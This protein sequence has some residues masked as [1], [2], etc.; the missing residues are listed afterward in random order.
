MNYSELANWDGSLKPPSV[1]HRLDLLSGPSTLGVPSKMPH[2][3]HSSAN[4]VPP[5]PQDSSST[6]P[7]ASDED[8]ATTAL[9]LPDSDGMA[10]D[11]FSSDTD[12][13][14][15]MDAI[16]PHALEIE[17]AKEREDYVS[18]RSVDIHLS[19]QYPDDDAVAIRSGKSVEAAGERERAQSVPDGDSCLDADGETDFGSIDVAAEQ[20]GFYVPVVFNNNTASSQHGASS[21]SQVTFVNAENIP[22]QSHSQPSAQKI[23]GG[24]SVFD[25]DVDKQLSRPE[26]FRG[27]LRTATPPRAN[28]QSHLR[29]SFNPFSS[30]LTITDS[31]PLSVRH[32]KRS[33]FNRAYIEVPSLPSGS[34]HEDYKPSTDFAD[35]QHSVS[36]PVSRRREYSPISSMASSCASQDIPLLRTR[37]T[38]SASVSGFRNQNMPPAA[39]SSTSRAPTVATKKRNRIS[40]TN[41]PRKKARTSA[42]PLFSADPTC[43]ELD[44]AFPLKEID[45]L[46]LPYPSPASMRAAFRH[47]QQEHIPA[48]VNTAYR[49]DSTPH[50]PPPPH[51]KMMHFAALRALVEYG[52]S[53]TPGITSNSIDANA[54]L[55]SPLP[56]PE[57]FDLAPHTRAQSTAPYIAFPPAELHS[58]FS[59][60]SEKL[61]PHPG[62]MYS[63]MRGDPLADPF[64]QFM[65]SDPGYDE[66][67]VV[68]P[69]MADEPGAAAA[70]PA[71]L[72]ASAAYVGNGT[73]DPS[74]LGAPPEERAPSPTPS[75]PP[76]RSSP[77]YVTG[78]SEAGP[79]RL[80][81]PAPR[82]YTSSE[83]TSESDDEEATCFRRDSSVEEP[84]SST[85]AAKRQKKR[86]RKPTAR[87]LAAMDDA[88]SDFRPRKFSAPRTQGGSETE[89]DINEESIREFAADATF[90]HHCRRTSQVEKMR[91]T[92]MK[93]NGIPC[94]LRFCE[95]CIVTR[96]PS[97]TFEPYAVKFTCPRC[98]DICNCTVCARKRGEEYVSARYTRLALFPRAKATKN[99]P[100]A[101]LPPPLLAPSAGQEYFGAVYG[102]G[103][104][105]VGL[106]FGDQSQGIVVKAGPGPF[107]GRREYV[108]VARPSW[109][110]EAAVAEDTGSGDVPDGSAGSGVRVYVGKREALD[111]GYVSFATLCRSPT[112]EAH[113]WYPEA[114]TFEGPDCEDCEVDGVHANSGGRTPSVPQDDLGFI[115]AQALA[116]AAES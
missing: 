85:F 54:S 20:A 13:N 24:D 10:K 26:Q 43:N 61:A 71:E 108:G 113:P 17:L 97:L 78:S 51:E 92:V 89:L 116:A 34:R 96:Y 105:R 91:C 80:H 77:A 87:A 1:A 107:R 3:S 18:S 66:N 62:A 47:L 6:T 32:Q 44:I 81:R 111:G 23:T 50:T 28:S 37:S 70:A 22:M 57:H 16:I 73:I 86:A 102:L 55:Q 63:A 14:V 79:S 101:R 25:D 88:D 48:I 5:S 11:A 52:S 83:T 72:D 100:K 41:V 99:R 58:G 33:I 30:P 36:I 12:A 109:P 53:P 65:N 110:K 74:L 35:L 64:L 93:A 112:P 38:H 59:M 69:W 49:L 68:G 84:L 115:I 56:S 19:S 104:E 39:S 95:I 67:G 90:C 21:T 31:S 40:N 103:G 82:S 4:R 106:A 46:D 8:G 75:P 15:T 29:D 94:G 42:H 76:T 27:A 7:W 114:H 9:F 98:A 60:P 45:I 2:S